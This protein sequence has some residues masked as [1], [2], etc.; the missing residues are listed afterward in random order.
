M[1]ID[2]NTNNQPDVILVQ[3]PYEGP[4]NFWK[5]ENLGMGYLASSLESKGYSVE[6]LDAFLLD[7]SIDEVVT[8]LAENPP[9]LLLG[10]SILSYQNGSTFCRYD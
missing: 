6:I 5:S 3:P 10:F 9:R 7:M 4:Y 1:K 8:K 2:G